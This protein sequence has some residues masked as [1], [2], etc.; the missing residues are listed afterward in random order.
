[1]DPRRRVLVRDNASTDGTWEELQAIKA[2]VMSHRL[3]IVRSEE[4]VPL[5]ESFRAAFALS[6]APFVTVMG[7]DD[8][9]DKDYLSSVLREFEQDPDEAIG[10]VSCR[11]R[12][13]DGEG[14]PYA[15]A[16]DSR[17]RIPAP[18]CLPRA[19]LKQALRFGNMHFGLNTYRRQLIEELGGFDA[20]AGWLIDWDLYLRILDSHEIKIIDRELCS[21]G[22]RMDCASALKLEQLP[23]QHAYVNHVRRKAFPASKSLKLAIATPF[24]MSQE[25]SHYGESLLYTCRML[26]QA[27][28]DWELIRV[29]G[30]S[31]VDR[32]KNTIVANFLET[33]CTDLLIIDSDEQWH[34]NA[35]A[36]LL[37]HPEDV[38]AGA[39]PFKNKWGQFAGNPLLETKDGKPQYAGWREIGD[40]SCLLEAYNIAGGF[41]RLKRAVLERFVDAYPNDIYM[42][43]CAW[44]GREGRIYSA[45]FEC[46]RHHF[47]RYGEDAEFSRKVRDMGVKLWI[48]P[49]ITIGHYGIKGWFGNLHEHI[50]RPK[51][52]RDRLAAEAEQAAQAIKLVA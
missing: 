31:Y 3:K 44:P 14:K 48:D 21:L 2:Q 27:G 34:P 35:V 17:T 6:S 1:L 42:D 41:L 20:K 46:A 51:E 7:A 38:V 40:G 36:R 37:Q 23:E 25:F 19:D 4:C 49:A 32:A 22:I 24:Y 50:L 52:E 29:N 30:D 8:T 9:L 10:M 5:P 16:A 28:I 13:I 45:F 12:F 26:T 39:Y 18:P 43:D 15:N 47:Q 33:D 11:P